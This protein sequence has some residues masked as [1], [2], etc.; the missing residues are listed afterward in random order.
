[1]RRRKP[2]P[3]EKLRRDAACD[4]LWDY[5]KLK[6]SPNTLAVFA[7][8]GTGP[9][10]VEYLDGLRGP[11]KPLYTPAT[12]DAWV[13]S[14]RSWP[15]PP[16]RK[17]DR[18]KLGPSPAYLERVA[19]ERMR[20]TLRNDLA[21]SA[22][23]Q[24]HQDLQTLHNTQETIELQTINHQQKSTTTPLDHGDQQT[25]QTFDEQQRSTTPLDHDDLQSRTPE[26][27]STKMTERSPGPSVAGPSSG[28]RHEIVAGIPA[29]DA[30]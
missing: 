23:E 26:T 10:I 29:Q 12:L 11:P 18:A 3:D 21:R 28:H 1:M 9:P 22:Y 13:E 19:R 6:Y 14:R 27:K 8:W 7:S 20:D 4:Y 24:K 25:H 5:H 17:R 30:S 15:K 16:A 2:E